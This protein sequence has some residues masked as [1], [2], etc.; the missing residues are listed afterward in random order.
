MSAHPDV[1]AMGAALWKTV[2]CPT[3][4]ARV[5]EMCGQH[6]NGVA[7]SHRSAYHVARKRAAMREINRAAAREKS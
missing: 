2:P 4:G 7:R 3:C 6:H 5:E 1:A